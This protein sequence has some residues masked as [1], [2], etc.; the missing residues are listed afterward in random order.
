MKAAQYYVILALALVT[1]VLTVMY[2]VSSEA[3]RKLRDDF[4]LQ[5]A[6]IAQ[7]TTAER[8]VRAM[9]NDLARISVNNDKFKD[10]LTRH[11][12]SVEVQSAEPAA[13]PAAATAAPEAGPEATPNAAPARPK[14]STRTR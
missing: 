12:F 11:G 3:N 7:G 9:L 6:R 5:S 1:L 14:S 10:L 8:Y 13:P 4:E 2:V